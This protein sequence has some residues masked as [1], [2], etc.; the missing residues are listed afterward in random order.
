MTSG[1]PFRTDTGMGTELFPTLF[2]FFFAWDED[3]KLVACGPSLVKICADAQTGASV[4]DVFDIKRPDTSFRRADILQHL[5]QLFLVQHLAT[6]TRFRGQLLDVQGSAHTIMLA[7]PWLHSADEIEALG[8]TF[9][10]FALHDASVDLLQVLQTQQ[11]AN[12]DLQQLADRLTSQRAQ[13]SKQEA[14]ARKLALVAARTDNA[15]VVTDARGRIEWVNDGFLRMTGWTIEEVIG[16]TPGQLLQGED[17]DPEVVNYMRTQIREGKGFTSEILNYDKKGRPYWV[18]I[19]VQP[20][21]D[22]KGEVVNFMA[23]ESDVTQRR[24]DTQ[25]LELQFS[26]SSFLNEADTVSEASARILEDVCRRLGWIVGGF[27]T[28]DVSEGLLKL[29]HMWSEPG[30]AL[31]PFIQ[32][33]K[34][35]AFTCGTGLPGHVWKTMKSHWVEDVVKDENFPRSSAAAESGL[36]GALAF[37]V[38]SKGSLLGV[39][40]FFSS[41]IQEPDQA[42]M[43]T[44]GSVGNQIGQFI[45]RKRAEAELVNAKEQAESANRAKSDFLATMSHEIRTPMNGVIGMSSLLLDSELDSAQREMAEAVRNSG[46]ALMFIIDDILDFSKIEARKLDLIEEPFSLESI[47]SDVIDLVAHRVNAKG[48][49]M[50]LLTE[51]GI[52]SILHGDPGRLRQVLLNL[53]GNATKFTDEGEVALRV[54]M[55]KSSGA[56][57][58]MLQFIVEDTGIGMTAEQQAKLF[59]PFT[60]V[61]GSSTRRFGGT[62]LGLAIS[63]RLIE[64]M[65][66]SISVSSERHV[67]SKFTFSLPLLAGSVEAEEVAWPEPDAGI[68]VLVGDPSQRSCQSIRTALHGLKR[69]PI[70]FEREASLAS[71]LL[72]P[73]YR[74]DVLLIDQRLVGDRVTAALVELDFAGRKPRTIFMGRVAES[75]RA[76]EAKASPDAFVVKP[77]RRQQL[78]QAFSSADEPQARPETIVQTPGKSRAGAQPRLLI[79]EDNEVNSRLATMLLEKLGY[80]SELAV[81]GMEAIARFKTG[82]YDGILMDCHMPRMDGYEATRAIRAIESS[83]GWKR[84]SVRIIAMTANAMPGEREHCLKV[85]MDDYLAKPLRSVLLEEALKHVPLN[86]A[87]DQIHPAQLWTSEDEAA[88]LQSIRVLADELSPDSA[89]QLLGNWLMTAP[90]RIEEI[91]ALAGGEDQAKLRRLAHSLKGS[92]ALFGLLRIQEVCS[93]LEDLAAAS[94][95]DAEIPA[96]TQLMLAFEA[97]LPPLNQEL[98]SLKQRRG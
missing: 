67:G 21:L 41:R 32:A 87:A 31:E 27:W 59:E 11:M 54:R 13:L 61:D 15:V 42:L 43:Q 28:L 26:V 16:K 52:P 9:S 88:A 86:E 93:A 12:K 81:D 22:Q 20:V 68:Q 18:A 94:K 62:G 25:R 6:G 38:I 74:W 73:A 17:T 39:I 57:P 19:E 53:V 49:E 55:D 82:V 35:Q 51:P 1:A 10:D 46:E 60:Q 75:F 3:L 47:I 85:G 8:V 34:N 44:M 77:V 79:V 89:Y 2:P 69:D 71:A 98:E 83:P 7:S 29:A 24:R 4:A 48:L 58:A 23:I 92:S 14:E 64:M 90:R 33:S 66:G 65:G 70:F 72:D 63:R 95:L 76:K 45:A 80:S 91:L 96:A 50:H 78:K 97:A 37:P 84:P 5:Q 56:D 30:T 36:H 40:E